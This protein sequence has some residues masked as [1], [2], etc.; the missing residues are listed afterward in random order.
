MRDRRRVVERGSRPTRPGMGRA[1]YLIAT[2]SVL[3]AIMAWGRLET[4][5][6]NPVPRFAAILAVVVLAELPA[7]AVRMRGA[8]GFATWAVATLPPFALF[9]TYLGIEAW[10]NQDVGGDLQGIETFLMLV[11]VPPLV[12]TTGSL[13]ALLSCLLVKRDA[14]RDRGDV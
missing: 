10:R 3:V 2:A 6:G 13:V 14:V 12:A 4:A 8:T 7:A 11:V 5:P 9:E 1:L